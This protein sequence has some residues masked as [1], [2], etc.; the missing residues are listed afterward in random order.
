M[1]E[2]DERTPP[3]KINNNNIYNYTIYVFNYDNT[4]TTHKDDCDNVDEEGFNVCD[5]NYDD[6]GDGDENAYDDNTYDYDDDD[7]DY[8]DDDDDTYIYILHFSVFGLRT[9]FI[10]QSAVHI[11]LKLMFQI[12]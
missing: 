12:K 7:D 8:C 6:D 5:D 1:D 11:F 4:N 2:R 3:N 9:V 10:K